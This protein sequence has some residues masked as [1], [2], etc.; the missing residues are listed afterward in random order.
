MGPE[1]RRPASVRTSRGLP[2]AFSVAMTLWMALGL[3]LIPSSTLGAPACALVPQLREVTINQGLGSYPKLVQGKE[4]LV[5]AY[6]SL[7]SCASTTSAIRIVGGALTVRAGTLTNVVQAPFQARL[8]PFPLISPNYKNHA[9]GRLA[10]RSEVG[11]TGVV[12]GSLGH[13]CI[14]RQLLDQHLL[15]VLYERHDIR[16]DADGPLHEH[17]QGGRA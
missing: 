12:P 4:T 5:R 14:H 11:G 16:D 3:S 10:R 2:R 8:A 7:P 17:Q 1:P 13:R 6:L 15:S 9:A